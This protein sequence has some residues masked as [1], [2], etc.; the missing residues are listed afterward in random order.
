MSY[1]SY[2]YQVDDRIR[3]Y[4]N[5]QFQGSG[6]VWGFATVPYENPDYIIVPDEAV[7]GQKAVVVSQSLMSK[8]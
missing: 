5:E 4:L 7:N 6:T 2:K 1:L 8:N 3:F